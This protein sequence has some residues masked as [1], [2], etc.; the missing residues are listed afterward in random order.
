MG[1]QLYAPVALPAV[2]RPGTHCTGDWVRP[3]P[4]RA[5]A[6]NPPPGL[7]PRTVQPVTSRYTDYAITVHINTIRG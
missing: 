5:G 4:V 7:D 2:K 6:E 1:G 3:R